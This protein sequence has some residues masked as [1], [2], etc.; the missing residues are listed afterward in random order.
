MGHVASKFF[1]GKKKKEKYEKGN[2]VSQEEKNECAL[3]NIFLEKVENFLLQGLN[4]SLLAID[5]WFLDTGATTHIKGR[6]DLF[7][8]VD[9]S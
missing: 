6:K 4:N 1:N 5:L 3:L 8:H 2:L 7:N 9:E